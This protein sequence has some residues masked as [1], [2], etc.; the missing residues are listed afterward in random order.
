MFGVQMSRLHSDSLPRHVSIPVTVE[1]RSFDQNSGPR[2]VTDAI[3]AVSRASV[4]YGKYC[5]VGLGVATFTTVIGSGIAFLQ[6][7]LR[8]FLSEWYAIQGLPLISLVIFLFLVA[9]S[10]AFTNIISALTLDAS[11]PSR[12]LSGRRTRFAIM[13]VVSA[14]SILSTAAEGFNANGALLIFMWIIGVPFFLI[15]SSII[16]HLIDMLSIIYSLQKIKIKLFRYN[17]ANTKELRDLISYATTFTLIGTIAYGFT[18]LATVKGHWVSNGG[19]VKVLQMLWPII[20]VPMC[21]FALVYPHLV[22]HRLIR[23][24]KEHILSRYR[25]KINDYFT[26]SD[27]NTTDDLQL[28]VV[29]Q[30][31]DR[32]NATPEYVFDLSIAVRTLVPLVFNILTL[33]IKKLFN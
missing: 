6:R 30:L 26:Y 32:I 17:P 11:V 8:H 5:G 16:L 9:R 14:G 25:E 21:S 27:E 33:P 23:R 19:Y 31:F 10:P 1:T 29:T 28:N 7:D 13:F 22:V 18:L 24:E 2:Y 15:G 3:D 4:P 12:L 20:F